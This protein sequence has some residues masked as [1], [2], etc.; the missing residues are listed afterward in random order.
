MSP[1]TSLDEMWHVMEEYGIDRG[2]LEST[3]PSKELL[4]R[5]YTAIKQVK[6]RTEIIERETNGLLKQ[7]GISG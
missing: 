7:D 1:E 4:F 2:L 3:N 6:E 5:L